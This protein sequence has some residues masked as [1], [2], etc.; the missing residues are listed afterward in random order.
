MEARDERY[1]YR[2]LCAS[3]FKAPEER[4][5]IVIRNKFC[6]KMKSVFQS[7]QVLPQ[8]ELD[9]LDDLVTF[10]KFKKENFY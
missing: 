6:F 10:R 3:A 1:I 2:K 5:C 4:Y 7:I 9:L 8:N